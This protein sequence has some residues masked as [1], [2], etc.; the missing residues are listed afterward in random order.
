V[1]GFFVTG[2][3]TGIG[4]TLVSAGL[5]HAISRQGLRCAGM[6]P[7]AAGFT[8]SDGRW[9]NDDVEMLKAASNVALEDALINPCALRE[10]LAPHI[11]AE[12]EGRP[13]DIERIRHA[14]AQIAALADVIIIEGVGGFRVPLS[15]RYDT[16]HLAADLNMPVILVVG[17]RLG[18]L[19]HALLTAEAIASRGLRLAGW[20]ANCID[21]DMAARDENIAALDVHLEAPRVGVVPNLGAGAT[22]A[23]AASHLDIHI[24]KG[25]FS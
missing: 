20:V 13:I 21:P 14:A 5:V 8:E 17:M 9:I 10:P 3:D 23:G 11:A 1:K 15:S 18:C 7:V 6:K 4:K 24:L 2:T 19:N 25:L 16:A 22:A 12:R